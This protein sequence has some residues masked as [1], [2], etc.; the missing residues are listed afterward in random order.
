MKI[1]P[2]IARSLSHQVAQPTRQLDNL[3]WWYIYDDC[4]EEVRACYMLLPEYH[5]GC[6]TY[7]VNRDNHDPQFNDTRV[8]ISLIPFMHRHN[9]EK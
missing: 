2:I 8:Q 5:K 9:A 4:I 3:F 6:V 7:N 1:P